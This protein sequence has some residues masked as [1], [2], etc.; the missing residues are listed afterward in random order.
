MTVTKKVAE[1]IVQV[2]QICSLAEKLRRD[3]AAMTS[4]SAEKTEMVSDMECRVETVAS[5]LSEVSE[6]LGH[7]LSQSLSLRRK[8]S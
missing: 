4:Y 6:M 5:G 3:L 2:E 1:L 8:G 7:V